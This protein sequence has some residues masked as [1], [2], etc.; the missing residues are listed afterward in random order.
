M[1]CA[2]GSLISPCETLPGSFSSSSQ[3]DRYSAAEFLVAASS[4]WRIERNGFFCDVIWPGRIDTELGDIAA[5]ANNHAKAFSI[6]AVLATSF[7]PYP[8]AWHR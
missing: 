7:K 2:F 3:Y 5:I 4:F 6:R 1:G 8:L